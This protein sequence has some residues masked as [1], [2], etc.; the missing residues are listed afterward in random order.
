MVA[1]KK[2]LPI[3]KLD[4]YKKRIINAQ[5]DSLSDFKKMIW[6]KSLN[7]K[8]EISTAL[9]WVNS[10]HLPSIEEMADFIGFRV[11]AQMPKYPLSKTC[12]A[13]WA[14]TIEILQTIE[15]NFLTENI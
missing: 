8:D 9:C 14:K 2:V 7:P 13:L 1:N 12:D 11:W 10:G 3:K 5:W 6:A 15:N 4:G